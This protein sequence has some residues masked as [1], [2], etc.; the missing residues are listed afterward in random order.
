MTTRL[1]LYK[2]E[3]H[4]WE[5]ANTLRGSPFLMSDGEYQACDCVVAY[6]MDLNGF[7]IIPKQD[8]TPYM[9]NNQKHWRIALSLV[10]KAKGQPCGNE[11][12]Y[13]WKKIHPDL[14]PCKMIIEYEM[15]SCLKEHCQIVEE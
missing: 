12:L 4:Q 13:A 6:F 14:R 3:S 7:Y 2:F 11:Y 5:A 10:S 1:T 9:V 15:Q 8:F